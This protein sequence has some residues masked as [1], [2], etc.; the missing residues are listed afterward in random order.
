[1]T[2]TNAIASRIMVALDVPDE[3]AADALLRR[4]EGIP[5]YVKVGMELFYA[6]GP[7]LVVRLKEA[8]YRVFLD[9]KMHDIPNTVKGG[10]ASVTRLGVDMFNVH[11]AG[12]IAMMEAAREGVESALSGSPGAVRP[13]VIGVTQLTSVNR[14]VLNDQIGIAGTVEDAVLRYAELAKR[15]GLDGVVASPLETARIKERC[16]RDFLAVTPGIRPA[17]AETGDQARVMT[18][19]EAFRQGADYIVIGRPIT[20]APDPRRALEDIIR[21]VEGEIG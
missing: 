19:R 1:M 16:G 13:V 5:C 9:V 2:K 17:G 15:A 4:L 12:G 21:S 3:S 8:G 20:A 11:A 10:A 6:A 18:P 14:A 7:R